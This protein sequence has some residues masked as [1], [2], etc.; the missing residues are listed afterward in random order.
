MQTSSQ[1]QI[2]FDLFGRTASLIT[3]DPPSP[4]QKPIPP[5]FFPTNFQW[6]EAPAF[7]QAT[8]VI[9]LADNLA[10][11]RLLKQLGKKSSPATPEEQTILARYNGWGGLALVFEPNPKSWRA[12][13]DELK[14][15][16]TTEEYQ[17]AQSTVNT[18][19][20]T[21]WFITQVMYQGLAR[22]GVTK[23]RVL[24]PAAG[25]GIF[26]AS[27]PAHWQLEWQAVEMDLVSGAIL[28]HL[29]PHARIQVCG[30]QNAVL[31][32]AGFDLILGNVPFGDY[33]IHDRRLGSPVIHDYFLLRSVELVRPGGIVA[34][35]T[36]RGTLDKTNSQ[37]RQ[38][39]A[40][41][42][43][44][45]GAIR[46][47]ESTFTRRALTT[48]TTDILFLQRRN[49]PAN[50]L[51]DWIQTGRMTDGR[52]EINQYY[53]QHPEMIIGEMI[54]DA[55]RFGDPVCRLSKV[56]EFPQL[57]ARAIQHLPAGCYLESPKPIK[58]AEVDSFPGD[59]VSQVKES[60][61]WVQPDGSVWQRQQNTLVKLAGLSVKR[62]QRIRGLLKIRDAARSCLAA[63]TS[64]AS[65]EH[66]ESLREQLNQVYDRFV[67][68]H[69]PISTQANQR[70]L[71]EDPD[72]PFLL[73]LEDFDAT[74]QT[75]TKAA[76]FSR[77]TLNAEAVITKADTA[78]DAL[79]YSLHEKGR[80]DLDFIA[81]LTGKPVGQLV[82]EL[83][84]RI[85]RNPET[86]CWETADD[87]LSGIVAHK[88]AVVKKLNCPDLA[89]NLAALEAVQPVPLGPGEI[90][91]KLG[92]PWVPKNFIRQFA[93]DLLSGSP[94]SS[95]SQPYRKWMVAESIT[96]TQIHSKTT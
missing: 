51:P 27:Q 54:P 72:L 9:K 36:A 40:T 62:Q 23:G 50:T 7:E 38:R 81:N 42:C 47:P 31:P 12:E 41:H 52:L 24:E 74:T 94:T 82:T 95:A 92:A 75:A 25:T 10:A 91:L 63:Q 93:V 57:I 26:M 84:G 15:L 65:D 73:A 66:W 61:Y 20:Y 2:E 34:L 14:A 78:A 79:F 69:G 22:L 5:A 30:L 86:K 55:G 32:D 58:P 70:A 1:L 76:C 59:V 67:T 45:L 11:L 33:P 80:V 37:I 6:Q 64:G 8:P 39:L 68:A 29:Q 3:S 17:A 48:V 44:L 96:Q 53:I 85:Y 60:G 21:P 71:T 16:L 90:R 87:Y 89:A 43:D 46:L 13:A 49:E 56:D 18:A 88:L 77:R 35:I 83:A 4:M 19:F 28:R